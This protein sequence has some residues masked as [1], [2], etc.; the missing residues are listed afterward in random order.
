[1]RILKLI[2]FFLFVTNDYGTSTV[3]HTD[4]NQEESQKVALGDYNDEATPSSEDSSTS[5]TKRFRTGTKLKSTS[6]FGGL[7]GFKGQPLPLLYKNAYGS[8]TQANSI[9]LVDANVNRWVRRSKSSGSFSE[10]Q[11]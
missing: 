6:N 5:G 9:P 2:I 4:I 10:P 8:I 1:M 11:A 7:N 3:C